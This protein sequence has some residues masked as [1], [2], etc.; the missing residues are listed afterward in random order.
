[1]SGY[2]EHL[3]SRT[4]ALRPLIRF[5]LPLIFDTLQL[6]QFIVDRTPQLKKGG[7][8]AR[9]VFFDTGATV[10]LSGTFDD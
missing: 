7:D 4:Y 8:E 2:M 3:V 5:F 9:V 10:S 1:M 6:D